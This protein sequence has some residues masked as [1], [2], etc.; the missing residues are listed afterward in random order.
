MVGV[1]TNV[2][3]DRKVLGYIVDKNTQGGF[4]YSSFMGNPQ[5]G[6]KIE[7]WSVSKTNKEGKPYQ[8]VIYAETTD[9]TPKEEIVKD[10]N[11]PIKVLEDK[12][13]GFIEGAL[14]PHYMVE[15]HNLKHE[16]EIQA[17]AVLNYN[18]AKNEWGWLVVKL[19]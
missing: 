17:K 4:N 11:G 14:I 3:K 10:L 9:K 15:K 2:K 1:V 13:I 12:K 5:P 7:L 18:K 16:E 6:D 8:K 19:K